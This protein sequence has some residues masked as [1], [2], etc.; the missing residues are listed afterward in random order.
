[1]LTFTIR[2]FHPMVLQEAP[3]PHPACDKMITVPSSP[4]GQCFQTALN[5][6]ANVPK[7]ML[8]TSFISSDGSERHNQPDN[9]ALPSHPASCQNY[10]ETVVIEAIGI[11]VMTEA[12]PLDSD[13]EESDNET[14]DSEQT[15]PSGV[16]QICCSHLG[17][18][19]LATKPCKSIILSA[20][21]WRP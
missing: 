8:P 19:V 6:D 15:R 2:D 21:D 7:H 18:Q 14:T 5:G 10:G 12:G 4:A 11:H 16:L 3:G 13:K 9:S 1:M 20:H 17:K